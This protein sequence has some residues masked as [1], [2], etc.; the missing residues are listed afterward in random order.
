MSIRRCVLSIGLVFSLLLCT[1]MPASAYVNGEDAYIRVGFNG[2]CAVGVIAG[3]TA[4]EL[5]LSLEGAGLSYV[6]IM[7]SDWTVAL[8]SDIVY[9][10]MIARVNKTYYIKVSVYG[11]VDGDGSVTV[12]DVTAMSSLYGAVNNNE[13]ACA[14]DMDFNGTVSVSDKIDLRSYIASGLGV[15][16]FVSQHVDGLSLDSAT[17]PLA[18]SHYRI[19]PVLYTDQTV[20][21]VLTIMQSTY[22]TAIAA[23]GS[24]TSISLSGGSLSVSNINA[25]SDNA[26]SNNRFIHYSSCSTGY[27]GENAANLV[28]ATYAKGAQIVLGYTTQ[29]YINVNNAWDEIFYEAVY[30]YGCSIDEAMTLADSGIS[31]MENHTC[32]YNRLIRGD[33]TT[34]L[35]HIKGIT[36]LQTYCSE[37]IS[38]YSSNTVGNT[39]ILLI[40]SDVQQD[41]KIYY[42]STENEA[43]YFNFTGL[44]TEVDTHVTPEMML[45]I[46]IDAAA[47]YIDTTEYV[48]TS[49]YIDSTGVTYYDFIRY[50]NERESTDR[51]CVMLREDGS[52]VS[53]HASNIGVY[54]DKD[55]P[56]VSDAEIQVFVEQSIGT[57]HTYEI[58]SVSYSLEEDDAVAL[59]I[60]VF[61]DN[62]SVIELSYVS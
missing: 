57:E 14:A 56:V 58:D 49:G 19:A 35:A 46:A 43:G 32:N 1:W 55:C 39:N 4:G 54:A 62:G 31:T 2:A 25:L 42:D 20:S 61:L 36:E 8:S 53:V 51:C 5:E 34:R 22:T 16:A 45:A 6:S 7:H 10:G 52:I 28:N 40:N 48:I 21:E 26:L 60:G 15:A 33:S 29:V 47:P 23:H 17:Y 11:D 27:G 59:H 41:G 9:T 37:L 24:S 38:V 44:N 13:F 30:R 3:T 50:I 18:Y 12:S